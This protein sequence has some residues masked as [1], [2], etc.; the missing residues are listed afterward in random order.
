M[1]N[2]LAATVDLFVAPL[3]QLFCHLEQRVDGGIL[4]TLLGLNYSA[5]HFLVQIG[6]HV[7]QCL[8]ILLATGNLLW[9]D[10]GCCRHT[11]GHHSL[12]VYSGHS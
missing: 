9:G 11:H 6:E 1:G 4:V 10:C 5:D 2:V 12:V 7:L 3:L 8:K